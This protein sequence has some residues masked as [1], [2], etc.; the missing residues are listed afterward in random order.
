MNII[1]LNAIDSTNKFLKELSVSK[2]IENFT[3]VV[4]EKQ[5]KGQGQRGASWHSEDGKNLTFS[6]FYEI[7]NINLNNLF[8]INIATS[9]AVVEALQINEI[10]DLNIKWPNDILSENKKI[11]G[12]LIENTIKTDGTTKSIIGIGLN[13]NQEKFEEL[14]QAS[15]L[16]ILKKREFDKEKLLLDLINK[17]ENNLKEIGNP[18]YLWEKYHSLLFKKDIPMA[19]ESSEK[20]RFMGI[21][22]G[23]SR[24]G[25]LILLLEEDCIKEFDIKEIKMLY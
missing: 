20:L 22:K 4:T 23:V 9:I 15:S 14:P 6:V 5:L 19:F 2:K 3:T 16:K 18:D 10:T 13:V 17:L 12:V 8:T 25:K 21:I 11:C 24:N 1:K 7:Q